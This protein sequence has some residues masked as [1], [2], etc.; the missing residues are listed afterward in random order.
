MQLHASVCLTVCLTQS[1]NYFSNYYSYRNVWSNK[2]EHLKKRHT[3]HSC[4]CCCVR[5]VANLWKK[6]RC[7]RPKSENRYWYSSY[8]NRYLPLQWSFQKNWIFINTNASTPFAGL[9][10][11]KSCIRALGHCARFEFDNTYLL[12]LPRSSDY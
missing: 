12:F 2:P 9:W 5:C 4:C 1:I 3:F 10:S 8:I 11:Q 6:Y 7:I